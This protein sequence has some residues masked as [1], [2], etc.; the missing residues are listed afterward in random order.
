M[1]DNQCV[2]IQYAAIHNNINIWQHTARQ[3]ADFLGAAF[4]TEVCMGESPFR[5]TVV[6][7][8]IVSGICAAAVITAGY[9]FMRDGRSLTAVI[10][11][12][13]GFA[14][15]CAGAAA[16]VRRSYR[17]YEETV[18]CL[19]RLLREDGLLGDLG[20]GH[21]DAHAVGK[22]AECL[23]TL[24]RDRDRKLDEMRE[25]VCESERLATLGQLSAGVA[26]EL[27]NPLGGILVYAHLLQED[28]D[29]NDARYSNIGKIIK[30]SN[31]C[32]TIIKSLLDFARQSHPVLTDA[33]MNDI[34]EDA[35]NNIRSEQMF[36]H[37]RVTK[38]L[39]PD[40]P[41]VQAD[42]S[43]IQ[44]VFENIIRNAAEVLNGSG[45]LIITSRTADSDRHGRCVEILFE[46][47]G[48]GIQEENMKQI[49]D[50]FYTTK[51]KG[52]GTGLGLAVSYGIVERHHGTIAVCNRPKGGASFTVTLRTG[53][54][55]E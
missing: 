41:V 28:T 12:A 34:V 43:Q 7:L 45:E 20:T 8:V 18:S 42:P 54:A 24:V 23:E 26:H 52:H 6:S 35:L 37:V 38:R 27:N 55:V 11:I 3:R 16:I 39:D 10:V 14:V 51:R 53:K 30:E 1:L 46:D 49:F 47:T 2:A 9:G 15:L 25:K 19:E 32:R 48:P 13:A 44:E 4:L 5:R 29:P 31:R 33:K 40:L 17:S 50:P 36:E 22:L 21:M